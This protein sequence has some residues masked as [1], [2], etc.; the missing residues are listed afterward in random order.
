MVLYFVP[1]AYDRIQNGGGHGSKSR[2]DVLIKKAKELISIYGKYHILF[3]SFAGYSKKSLGDK[4]SK[5][6]LSYQLMNYTK[7]EIEWVETY[8]NP[9]AWG[10]YEEVRYALQYVKQEI[11]NSSCSNAKIYFSTNL[12]HS[13][14]VRMCIWF[15]S[16]HLKIDGYKIEVVI[17]GHSFT[18]K[19]YAQEIVKFFVY[20][21][22]FMLMEF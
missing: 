11:K 2:C 7:R 12:G 21:Y 1:L 9:L 19:E 10:T 8:S 4:Q 22:K 18:K 15:L 17:A 14:R 3:L 5:K 16:R 20:L 13:P 6:T